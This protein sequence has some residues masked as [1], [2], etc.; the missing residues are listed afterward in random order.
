[1]IKKS[2][3]TDVI[4]TTVSAEII[5]IKN[6]GEDD[7]D[8]YL[9]FFFK[10]FSLIEETY[11]YDMVYNNTQNLVHYNWCINE[12]IEKGLIISI[13]DKF[14]SKL[15]KH[16]NNEFYTSDK[17]YDGITNLTE[18]YTLILNQSIKKNSNLKQELE[19][20]KASLRF[21]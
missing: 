6:V 19:F 20:L 8:V 4:T 11:F 10:L 13:E 2:K 21:S 17:Q 14:K 1:M 16:I 15:Y 5:Q 7:K 3:K 9:N 12:M 18:Y